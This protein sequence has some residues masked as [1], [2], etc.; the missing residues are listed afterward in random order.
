MAEGTKVEDY[1]R[2]VE[3]ITSKLATIN[4]TVDNSRLLHIVLGG[5]PL[6]RGP[7]VPSFGV[8]L[9]KTP[10]PTPTPVELI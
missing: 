5:L 4:A 2:E 8:K 1:L 6:S 9:S 3:S 10:T 7:F